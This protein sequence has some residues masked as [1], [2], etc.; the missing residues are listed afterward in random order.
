[1]KGAVYYVQD[2]NRQV[3]P[4]SMPKIAAM[5]REEQLSRNALYWR[6]GWEHWK[7][8]IGSVELAACH[9]TP[10]ENKA[11]SAKWITLAFTAV[12]L[13]CV[14]YGWFAFT[15]QKTMQS[16]PSLWSLALLAGIYFFPT[17]LSANRKHLGL[18]FVLNLLFG[19][20]IIV[21][22]VCILVALFSPKE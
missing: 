12:I 7:P 18:V 15:H 4:E 21:W 13:C 20:T 14:A 2:G 17:L 5:W 19:W 9:P 16:L 3:G 8:L 1:M 10:P 22:V 11:L 6:E